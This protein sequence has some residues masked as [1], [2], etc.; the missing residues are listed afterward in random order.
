MNSNN[1]PKFFENDKYIVSE[2]VAILKFTN[3]YDVFDSFGNM[4]G[5]VKQNMSA[6]HKAASLFIGK[7]MMPFHFDIVDLDDNVLV[8][9]SRGWTFW[10]SNISVSTGGQE[11]ATI[12][13]K[14]AM[15][16]PRFHINDINGQ[17]IG[18]IAGNWHAWNFKITDNSG[19]EIGKIDKKWNGVFKEGFTTADK[20]Q[21]EIDQAVK[22]NTQKVVI[23]ATAIAVDMILKEAQ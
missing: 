13:Q 6:G 23:V 7:S 19:Q 21:V 14:F 20:Y 4:I 22:E 17:Q 3:S 16:K 15:M 11:I 8:S 9:I 2:K 18:E 10:M 12:N 5:R 1:F